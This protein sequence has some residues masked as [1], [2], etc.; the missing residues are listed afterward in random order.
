MEKVLAIVG[1]TAVGKTA[2][3][4]HLAEALQTE[5]I[6][7][8]A[9]QI[10]RTMDIGTAKPTREEL[11]Q[12]RHH[13]IDIAE[14]DEPY[15][16]ARFGEMAR[17]I[18]TDLQNRGKIPILVGGTGLYIQSFLEGFSFTG[19]AVG[20]E[21]RDKARKKIASMEERALMDYIRQETNWEPPDWHE[22]LANTQRLVRLVAAIEKGE[23]EAFV[24]SDK[25][26]NLSYDAYV[27]GLTLPRPVLYER[28]E[29]RVD[30]MIEEGWI[31]ETKKLL[32]RGISPQCQSMKAIGY[33]EIGE[34]LSGAMTKEEAIERIK[35]R[36]RQFAKRQLT[37]F[38][39]MEYIHWYEKDTYATEEDLAKAVLSDVQAW[40][41]R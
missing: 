16:A 35:I 4:F 8:D 21:D 25:G 13:L 34:F 28:I 6:S 20:D 15:S 41:D 31:D 5:L 32:E 10:Y 29:K 30:M 3:S 7:C 38:K 1:P 36:T 26:R 17:P 14:P 37:W 27:I 12:Y 9:Y 11:Q 40:N 24:R 2:L 39:R 22:L 19:S 33:G 18:V 23:G